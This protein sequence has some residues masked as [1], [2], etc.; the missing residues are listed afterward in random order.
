MHKNSWAA[1]VVVI[2]VILG[3]V[4][5]FSDISGDF[6][7]VAT[8]KTLV[9]KQPMSKQK[10]AP[11][12]GGIDPATWDWDNQNIV[13]VNSKKVYITNHN[14]NPVKHKIYDSG[15]TV[16]S[17]EWSPDGTKLLFLERSPDRYYIRVIDKAG[18]IITMLSVSSP[19][20]DVREIRNPVWSAN[21][22]SIYYY[23]YSRGSTSAVQNQAT[24]EVTYSCEA[25][26]RLV[27]VNLDNEMYSLIK[28]ES[29]FTDAA[30]ESGAGSCRDEDVWEDAFSNGDVTCEG[31]GV[32]LPLSVSSD[33]VILA[34][35]EKYDGCDRHAT[36]A[37]IYP[38]GGSTKTID[39]AMVKDAD[40]FCDGNLFVYVGVDGLYSRNLNTEEIK[41]IDAAPSTNFVAISDMPPA[42]DIYVLVDGL[43]LYDYVAGT[44]KRN[45]GLTGSDADFKVVNWPCK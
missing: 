17:P 14:A 1:F 23:D 19:H 42:M 43:G 8:T 16:T 35:E 31:D 38:G 37:L 45:L 6:T 41:L 18:T 22:R 2:L 9:A 11:K 40:W 3:T 24:G 28:Y 15:N 5:Y 27:K 39:E 44:P 36:L 7:K 25:S 4:Y 33:G 30:E 29:F 12:Q 10:L 32:Y 34:N 13:Y 21:S 20:P 26:M